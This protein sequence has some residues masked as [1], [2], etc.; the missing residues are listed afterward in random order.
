MRGTDVDEPDKPVTSLTV[1]SH[2][3]AFHAEQDA[4]FNRLI[5]KFVS[6]SLQSDFIYA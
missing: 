1:E 2:C 4:V 3:C 6:A 5:Q